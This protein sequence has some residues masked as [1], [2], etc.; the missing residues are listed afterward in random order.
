MEK[1]KT[2]EP[3]AVPSHVNKTEQLEEWEEKV[4][5]AERDKANLL[6]SKLAADENRRKLQEELAKLK[7]LENQ[8]A[9]ECLMVREEHQKKLSEIKEYNSNLSS[10]IQRLK[11]QLEAKKLKS[12]ELR[13][14]CRFRKAIPETKVKFMQLES[15]TD[16]ESG[17][18]MG[19]HF[20]ISSKV[21]MKLNQGEALITFEE[22][23]VAQELI[24]KQEHRVNLENGKV[25]VLRAQPVV[26][27]TGVAFQLSAH[28]A[29]QKI[30]VSNI[31]DLNIPDEWMQ[32]KLELHFLKMGSGE[33]QNVSYN[34][35]FQGAQITFAQ[36]L[37]V[38]D[39]I[40]YNECPFYVSGQAH[41]IRVTPSIQGKVDGFQKF[42]GISQRT[43]LLTGIPE[44]EEEE[45]E[46]SIQDMIEIHFQKPSNGGGEVEHFK[47]VSKG[48]KAAYFEMEGVI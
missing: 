18:K 48:T 43:I 5:D 21:P 38:K 16:G 14:T 28:V 2:P 32:D 31:P 36:P 34:Q 3:K 26:L 4:A 19:G 11:E 35:L 15:A 20:Y 13:R 41:R 47:F 30:E 1:E 6:L 23:K 44:V 40:R 8:K 10:E 39:I 27:E 33:V 29:L 7:D 12:E 9:L 45:D 42:S 17:G 37:A 46:E 24:R 25:A 22:E